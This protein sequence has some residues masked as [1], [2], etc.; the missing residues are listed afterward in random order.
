MCS[1]ENG[2][3]RS[4]IVWY[5]TFRSSFSFSL[6]R[7]IFKNT[8]SKMKDDR[9]VWKS[10]SKESILHKTVP[11][12]YYFQT[13][14]KIYYDDDELWAFFGISE[15]KIHTYR[16]NIYKTK[17]IIVQEFHAGNSTRLMDLPII[18]EIT[19][20][21]L[22][23]EGSNFHDR[24][25]NFKLWISQIAPLFRVFPGPTFS[26]FSLFTDLYDGILNSEVQIFEF[27]FFLGCM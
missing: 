19:T 13:S 27:N 17:D 26:F 25:W 12:F 4:N 20:L 5:T 11:F 6:T 9:F 15:T 21:R 14:E 18:H 23:N 3:V 10:D 22:Q 7:I 24:V 16:Y 8:D 2:I 1:D